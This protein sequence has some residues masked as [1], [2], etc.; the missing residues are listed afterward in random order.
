MSFSEWWRF[1]RAL[2]SSKALDLEIVEEALINCG[3]PKY[4][5]TTVR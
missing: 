2:T 4:E 1:V 3:P 5:K